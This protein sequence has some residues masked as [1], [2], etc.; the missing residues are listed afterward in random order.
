MR[1]VMDPSEPGSAKPS[2]N[3]EA[4]DGESSAPVVLQVLPMLETGGVERGTVDIAAAIAAAGWTPLVVSGGGVMVREVERAGGE[5]FTLP[6]HSKNPLVMRRNIRAL[7]ALIR[8]RRVD[9]VHARSRAP[10]WCARFASARAG[11][12]F[13]TTFHGTYGESNYLKHKYN[14]VMSRGDRVIAISKFIA[15]RIQTL[16]QVGPD[17]VRIIPRGIDFTVFDPKAVS[18]ERMIQ[19]TNAWRLPD[20]VPVVLLPGR[21]T[22]WK[23]HDVLIEA[24]ARLGR[25]DL[26]CVLVGDDQ[27]RTGYRRSLDDHIARA[28][29]SDIVQIVGDCRDMASAYIVADVV[30]SASTDPEAFGRIA[31]EAQAMGRPV[32]ATDHGA[33]RE[34]VR[35]DG[36]T[37][38]LVPPGDPDALAAALEQALALTTAEREAMADRAMAH[39][40]ENFGKDDM[41]AKTLAVYRELMDSRRG[42]E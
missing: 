41:C 3:T 26:R 15:D 31:A 1:T 16:Y 33:A 32:I 36:V 4:V 13:M 42:A 30:V 25:R 29:L 40:R 34:T 14:S 7:E 2:N 9:I 11:V 38:W 8:E 19:L 23:G 37:G 22:R 21:L 28:G 35:A 39:I 20:G 17:R 27:G 18:A 12:K 10:A 6:V 5:H 24:L